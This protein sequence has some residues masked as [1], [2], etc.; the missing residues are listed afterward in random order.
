MYARVTYV[1]ALSSYEGS[2]ECIGEDADPPNGSRLLLSLPAATAAR[3]LSAASAHRAMAGLSDSTC[4]PV[5]THII[6]MV[7]N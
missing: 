7:P 4:R 2:L 6:I 1:L 3:A 5:H